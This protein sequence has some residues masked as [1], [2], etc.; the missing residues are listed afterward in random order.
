MK[1]LE[2]NQMELVEGGFSLGCGFA[3]LGA[4]IA[5]GSLIV[6]TGGTAGVVLAAAGWSI[7]PSAVLLSCMKQ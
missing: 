2:L 3:I 5:L 1:T 7:A 4:G 6:A